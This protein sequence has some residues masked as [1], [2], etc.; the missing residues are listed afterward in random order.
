[1]TIA[2]ADIDSW[3]DILPLHSFLLVFLLFYCVQNAKGLQVSINKGNSWHLL[4]ERIN[5]FTCVSILDKLNALQQLTWF[6][7]KS[8]LL[9]PGFHDEHISVLVAR[10]ICSRMWCSFVK[11]NWFLLLCKC[12]GVYFFFHA[13]N[14]PF[15]VI[16]NCYN[17]PK[18]LIGHFMPPSN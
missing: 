17:S 7:L 14:G 13:S 4:L 18:L 15:I 8:F 5:L 16:W 1:M 3:Q 2:T 11:K 9:D 6:W 10:H 12:W